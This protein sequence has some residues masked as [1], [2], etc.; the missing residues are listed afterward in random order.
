VFLI[1]SSIIA[2]L[3]TAAAAMVTA[4]MAYFVYRQADLM[5]RTHD[6]GV[7][8]EIL[9]RS[10]DN[11]PIRTKLR[12]KKLDWYKYNEDYPTIEQKLT[13]REWYDMS[14]TGSFFDFIGAMVK[15]KYVNPEILFSI[16]TIDEN[17]WND[18]KDFIDNMRIEYT[19][20]L[21]SHWEYL[22]DLQRIGSK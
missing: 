1:V 22:I 12:G 7:L 8:L 14:D 15:Y 4:L 20:D 18:N 13:N 3:A 10:H 9:R 19:S 5:Q 2:A 17:L 21:W 6:T 16:I 11:Y